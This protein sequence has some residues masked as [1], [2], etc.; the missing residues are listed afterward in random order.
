MIDLQIYSTVLLNTLIIFVDK[1]LQVKVLYDK[2]I[3]TKAM[4]QLR[5]LKPNIINRSALLNINRYTKQVYILI[6]WVPIKGCI[7]CMQYPRTQLLTL[8]VAQKSYPVPVRWNWYFPQVLFMTSVWPYNWP[9][10]VFKKSTEVTKSIIYQSSLALNK[11]FMTGCAKINQNKYYF[12][13]S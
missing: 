9:S 6:I 7:V 5:M 10:P 3:I 4:F 11:H 2:E 1:I 13:I 8:T 12:R